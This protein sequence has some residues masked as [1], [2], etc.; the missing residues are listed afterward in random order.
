MPAATY[1]V[2]ITVMDATKTEER[3]VSATLTVVVQN[4]PGAPLLSPVAQNRG[5]SGNTQLDDGSAN[6]SPITDYLVRWQGGEQ[7]CGNV[8]SCRIGN[9]H[10]GTTYTFTVRARNAIGWSPDSNAVTGRPNR[11]PEPPGQVQVRG[12]HRS[13]EVSWNEPDYAGSRPSSYTVQLQ[14]PTVGRRRTPG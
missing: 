1:H 6:G 13:V 12:G 9:L 4:V 14:G 8:T 2:V 7:S 10:N 11:A 3:S 5:F